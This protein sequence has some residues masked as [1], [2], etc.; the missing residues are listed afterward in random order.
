MKV[1]V[2][3]G[4]GYIGSHA[5]RCLL[6]RGHDV[7]VYDDLS[8]GH[9][10]AIDK[11]ASF[12]QGHTG[13]LKTL[14]DTLKKYSVEA[15]L[16]FAAFIEVGESVKDPGKY[17]ENN[18]SCTLNVLKAMVQEN[19]KKIVF[20][21]TAAV[22]GNPTKT[23]IE[24][25]AAC[26][27]INP[28]GR[29]K[30]ISEMIIHDHCQAHGLGYAILRYFNVAGAWPDGHMGEDHQPESHLIPKILLAALEPGQSVKI[31]GTDYPTADGT[32]IRDYLHVVDLAQAHILALKKITPGSG[33]IFN[34]GSES[35]FSVREV[36]STCEKVTGSKLKVDE[37]ARR[38]GDPAVLVASSEKIRRTLNWERKFPH[39]EQIIRHAWL[40]HTQHPKGYQSQVNLAS[41]GKVQTVSYTGNSAF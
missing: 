33:N 30:W 29:S 24:E 3:G 32:C 6:D 21:S 14:S 7:V 27:P 1:L 15:V 25:T 23:P 26:A 35:G 41:A 40:W 2:T 18:V 9:R 4:A 31:F 12:V 13:D 20:S 19:I 17:Y 38:P 16:H 34:L 11:R 36:I 5:V 10:E 37:E 22:Y 39:L 28:Y 8:K